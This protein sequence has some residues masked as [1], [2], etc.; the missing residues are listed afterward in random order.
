MNAPNRFP[1]IVSEIQNADVDIFC[2][3]E[4]WLREGEPLPDDG[5]SNAGYSNFSVPR[6]TD[7]RGGGLAFVYKSV[8]RVEHIPL[9]SF[10]SFEQASAQFWLY[11]Q[12]LFTV[13][14]VYRAPQKSVSVFISEFDDL[15]ERLF[16]SKNHIILGDFNIHIDHS[17]DYLAMRFVQMFQQYG[18]CQYVRDPTHVGGHILDLLIARPEDDCVREVSVHDYALSDHSLILC[19]LRFLKPVF[20]RTP[21]KFRN[22][23]KAN[24]EKFVD[25]LLSSELCDNNFLGSCTSVTTLVES[26]HKTLKSLTEKYVPLVTA[27]SFCPR[28]V[29]WFNSELKDAIRERRRKERLWRRSRD[30]RHRAEFVRQRNIVKNLTLSLKRSFYSRFLHE[31]SKSPRK[32]WNFV[33]TLLSKKESF[34]TPTF[35]NDVNGASEFAEYF[36]Q[37]IVNVCETLSPSCATFQ[38][39][40]V[41]ASP[42]FDHFE[43]MTME[44]IVKLLNKMNSKTCMLDPIPS[45]VIKLHPTV[46]APVLCFIVNLSMM[47][48]V[49]PISEKSAVI[50]P[51]LKKR[52]LNKE[53]LQNYRPVSQLS[54]VSKL[55][56]SAVSAQIKLFLTTNNLY[57]PNQSA[58]RKSHST[59][60]VLVHL[61]NEISVTRS[62]GMSSC[63]LL[64]DLSAAF[65]TVNHEILLERL[66]SSFYFSGTVLNW[67]RDYLLSRSQFVKCSNQLSSVYPITGGVPQGSVLGPLLYSLYV[68]PLSDIINDYNLLHHIYADDT[69]IFISFRDQIPFDLPILENCVSHVCDWFNWNRLK[70]NPSKT[71]LLVFIRT[72]NQIGRAHV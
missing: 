27:S 3:T 36:S 13:T 4:T 69:C 52:S 35:R 8:F 67:L 57:C 68:S 25:D 38:L 17:D 51:I 21:K 24:L 48:G 53:D 59:E 72:K 32:L 1:S 10:H 42:F 6:P 28:Y 7:T 16:A 26:Y 66:A 63:L 65:E 29:P 55:I 43:E 30:E 46:L 50:T 64:L 54:F 49:F 9:P 12:E 34:K 31:N 39:S 5:L 22:W 2:I 56:E 33:S 47:T 71:D 44:E 15:L 18:F 45:W 19:T 11:D 14:L 23:R 37:K 41:T 60:T 61:C 62:V 58:Y 70:V 40:P 20:R